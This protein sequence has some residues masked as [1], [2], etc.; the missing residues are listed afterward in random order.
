MTSSAVR[1]FGQAK[2][3]KTVH[4][5]AVLGVRA[6]GGVGALQQG[7]LLCAAQM[8]GRFQYRPFSGMP[9]AH[10]RCQSAS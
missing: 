9:V 7:L 4:G 6:I 5:L 2:T 1:F 10:N 3:A 8:E